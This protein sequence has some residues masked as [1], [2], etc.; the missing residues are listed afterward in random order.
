MRSRTSVIH[1]A[2]PVNPVTDGT[3]GET[4]VLA[5]KEQK[6]DVRRFPLASLA[7]AQRGAHNSR[8]APLPPSMSNEPIA[9]ALVAIDR[10]TRLGGWPPF[11]REKGRQ[12]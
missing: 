7:I 8:T 5:T 9:G 12:V 2:N 1:R 3:V 4:P 6:S 11:R 10:F